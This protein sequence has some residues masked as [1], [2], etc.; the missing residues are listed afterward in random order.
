MASLIYVDRS[1]VRP[2]KLAE[3]QRS[4]RELAAFVEANEP[5]LVSYTASFD[6]SGAHMTVIHIHR[7]PASLDRHMTVAGPR[8]APFADLVQLESIDIYGDPSA[9][10]LAQV[11]QKAKALGGATVTVHAL[12][13]GFV[14]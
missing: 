6:P 7:D 10:A 2:G 8:F 1:S 14:R 3:L 9:A 5:Q 11:R 12:H 13:G 4:I